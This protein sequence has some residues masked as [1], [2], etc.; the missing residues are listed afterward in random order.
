MKQQKLVQLCSKD[1][2]EVGTARN[3]RE[4]KKVWREKWAKT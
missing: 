2:S 4:E 1:D 3:I